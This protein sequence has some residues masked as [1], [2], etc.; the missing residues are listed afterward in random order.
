MIFQ[1]KRRL[2]SAGIDLTNKCNLKCPH[3]IIPLAER[4][5]GENTINLTK[6]KK[7]IPIL[8]K[9]GC[10]NIG[11]SGGEPMSHPDFREIYLLLK[12]AG[13]GIMLFTNGSYLNPE[14]LMFFRRYPIM[15][16]VVTLY[17]ASDKEY[18]QNSF[19]GEKNLFTRISQVIRDLPYA[20]INYAVQA[21]VLKNNPKL[22]ERLVRKLGNILYIRKGVTVYPRSERDI[23]NVNCSLLEEEIEN[24]ALKRHHFFANKSK[25]LSDDSL[26]LALAK[27]KNI[28]G[29]GTGYSKLHITADWKVTLCC[30]Y[31]DIFFD[32]DRFSLETIFSKKI[33]ASF[34]KK[35][36]PQSPC[37]LCKTVRY[38]IRCIALGYGSVGTNA[39]RTQLCRYAQ[40]IMGSKGESV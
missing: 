15:L 31:R 8:V 25:S 2:M 22:R 36:S 13:L 26:H 4:R 40:M 16:L 37:Y 6:L 24:I 27:K 35:I 21:R 14:W 7:L 1:K 5:T 38:C 17:G 9:L 11:L 18:A 20:G 12:K 30:F 10:R 32:L 23:S 34:N 19:S 29:C 33:P 3:C 39:L 28:F